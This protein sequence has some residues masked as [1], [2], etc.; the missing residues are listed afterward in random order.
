LVFFAYIYVILDHVFIWLLPCWLMLFSAFYCAVWIGRIVPLMSRQ[1]VLGVLDEISVI[2]PGRVFVYLTIC[3]VVLNRDDAVVW[4]GLLRR[5]LAGAVMIILAMS[6]CIA[7]TLLS[8]S[9]TL[10]FASILLDLVLSAAVIWLEHAQSTVIACL[11]AVEISNRL[12]GQVDRTSAAVATFVLVQ[13]LCYA[14]ALGAVMIVDAPSVGLT[15]LLFLLIR[16]LLV[17][18]LW[19]L[20]LHGANE[21][22]AD[23]LA[24]SWR[25]TVEVDRAF[26]RVN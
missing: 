7:L 14:V 17:S 8:E 26:S 6:L 12:G 2:P 18:A 16:E 4:L 22:G 10:E 25:Q 3:K 11:V 23:F 9:T 13:I 20:I 15:L 21:D 19:R 5:A 24:R 1:S